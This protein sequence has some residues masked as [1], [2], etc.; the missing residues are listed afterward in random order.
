MDENE[1]GVPL[2][3]AVDEQDVPSEAP[4]TTGTS[5]EAKKSKRSKSG[6]RR[7]ERGRNQF[8]KDT[9]IITELG[10]KG[11]P[12]QPSEARPKFWN[13]VG[14]IVKEELDISWNGW[15]QVPGETRTKCWDKMV[16]RFIFSGAPSRTCEEIFLS[17]NGN[18]VSELEV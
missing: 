7:G 2:F 1:Q 17:A 12:L 8:P 10:P 18:I 16:I 11:E 6:L 5:A 15:K 4:E 13:A 3:S 14:F 9:Y